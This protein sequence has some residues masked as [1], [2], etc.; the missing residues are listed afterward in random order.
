MTYVHVY[1]IYVYMTHTTHHSFSK[2]PYPL[3]STLLF[4]SLKWKFNLLLQ[5]IQ[6]FINTEITYVK[7]YSDRTF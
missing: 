4:I 7:I 1:R 6:F 2:T 3:I 5:S